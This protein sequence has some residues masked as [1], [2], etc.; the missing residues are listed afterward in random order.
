M[1]N[2]F[3]KINS[4]FMFIF[5]FCLCG[6]QAQNIQL[7]T[8]NTQVTYNDKGYYSSILVN[9]QEILQGK[10]Y[11][12]VIAGSK[13]Q[14]SF[15]TQMK[16]SGN[17]LKLVMSDGNKIVLRY[18]ESDDCIRLEAH[19]VAKSYDVLLFGPVGVTINDVVGEVIGVAQGG[20][21]A[22][23]VQA[24]N[25]KTTAGIPDEYVNGIA[26]KLKYEGETSHLSVSSVPG[27]KQA[28]TKISS[29][30]VFQMAVRRRDCQ[31]YR[32]IGKIENSLVLPVEG[33]DGV[34]KGA[35][36]A[37]FGCNR[38][39]AL[40][41]IGKIEQ[42][43]GLPH[44]ML[45]GEWAKVSRE[46]M[47]SYMITDFGENTLDAVLEKAQIA[48][49]DYVYHDGP[50]EDWGHF[51]W[52][53]EFT[54]NGDMGVKAMVDKAKALG[55]GLGVHTLSNFMTTNDAYVTPVPSKHLLKQ[56][57]LALTASIDKDQTEISIKKSDLFTMP[58]TLKGL[59][60]DDEL[61][62]YG[63]VEDKGEVM[64]LKNCKRG[65][66]G[67]TAAAHDLKAPLYKLWDHA[68]KVFLPDLK[69]QDAFSDRIAEIINKT[70]L[71]Q[72]SY[73]GLEGCSF[74][75]QDE[76]A[77]SRFV[78]QIYNKVNI[79]LRNDASRLSHNT[80]HLHT[81]TNWGEPWGE[82]MR[83]GQVE[84]RIKNQAFYRRNLFPRMLGW[85]LIRLADRRQECTSLE[86]LEWAMSEAA[87]FDAGYAMTIRTK[88]LRRH[89]QIDQLL[90][91]I[92]DWDYLREKQAF[93]EDQKTRMRD[94]KTE[95]HLEKLDD[96][97]FNL[98]PLFI[99]KRYTCNLGEMQPGQPGGSDWSWDTP[100][101]GDFAIR[102]KV[103]GDGKIKDPKFTTE[104]GVIMFPCEVSERQYL[105]YTFDGK[106]VVTD[107]NYNVIKEV[108]PEG[109]ATIPSGATA[110]SFTCELSS[111]D[112][113][114]VII[115]YITKG[116]PEKISVAK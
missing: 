85:F 76:Y 66:W 11:P 36:V 14:L 1:L 57:V 83:T 108:T 82:A 54:K 64:V 84:S 88:T 15:P 52:S 37:L 34:I 102:L 47:K 10:Q 8:S 115:R 94:P 44:P 90:E 5:L 62:S 100:Y 33:E 56:G 89:G 97:N 93:T 35:A 25:I 72:I 38:A 53:T 16:A 3:L 49:F 20:D 39:D 4:L 67:T 26:D 41:R 65:A 114:D 31:E 75:G 9:Q 87:G 17:Q 23:G 73:D 60:I 103:E 77:M 71:C 45:N 81:Y 116:Q 13:G 91:S 18:K 80:W 106:A 21:I 104:E 113:P 30:T 92:R 78:N 95:W 86:D 68:Y 2:R 42:S 19:S 59:Q 6:L 98:Y 24:L 79:P 46:S 43:E 74:T 22:F 99:S 12:I 51:N 109:E 105:L 70:G 69:L 107:K 40:E 7:K 111:E 29:G 58:M 50:F 55:I 63:T 28:A 48:G 112:A 96:Q 110:V 27:Y 61:L 32:K 101:K